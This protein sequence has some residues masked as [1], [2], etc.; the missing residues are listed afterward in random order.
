MKF[1]ECQGCRATVQANDI[2][3]CLGCQRGFLGV[4]QEDSYAEINRKSLQTR[5][6]EIEDAIQKSESKSLPVRKSPKDGRTVAKR[7][8]KNK[9][10]KKGQK[11]G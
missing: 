7:N 1:M 10:A 2:G 6:K 9:A 11:K 5:E 4:P 8:T 3:I